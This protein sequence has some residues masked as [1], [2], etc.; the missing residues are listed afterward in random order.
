LLLV[1]QVVLHVTVNVVLPAGVFGTFWLGGRTVRVG[2]P[3]AWVTVTTT[4]VS[5]ATVTVM[6]AILDTVVGLMAYDATMVPLPVPDGV[7]VHHVWFD[8]AVQSALDVTVKFVVPAGVAG[9]F[10][11]EGVTDSVGVAPAWVTVTVTV[12]APDAVTVIVATLLV[13]D[14][15]IV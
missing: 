3:A 7:T 12:G 13:A 4:G 14:V 9:T 8:A 2:A 10:W 6:L 15:F 5:V 11:F 1:V